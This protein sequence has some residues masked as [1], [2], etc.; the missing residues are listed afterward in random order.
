M[1]KTSY[2]QPPSPTKTAVRYDRSKRTWLAING[3]VQSF[4]AGPDAKRS[5][6]LAALRHDHPHLSRI[7]TDLAHGNPRHL[8]DRFIKAAQ[9]IC[10]GK[11]YGNG[12][13]ASQTL[14]NVYYTTRYEGFPKSYR[15][16]CP[17]LSKGMCKHTLAVHLAYLAGI[18]LDPTPF[19]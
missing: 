16:S 19:V 17:D 3:Q 18:D 9:L 12:V 13:V 15:C 6:M 10:S 5:A 8:V 1:T 7:V 2:P 11:V 14:K 4:G